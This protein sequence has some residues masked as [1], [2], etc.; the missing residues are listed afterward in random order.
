MKLR[1]AYLFVLVTASA[2][3][4]QSGTQRYGVFEHS[5]TAS[6]TYGN[7]YRE[8]DA[9]ATVVRPDGGFWRVPLF[10]DGENTWKLR[11]SPDAL[12]QWRYRIASNDGGLDG[13]SGTFTCT[14]SNKPGGIRASARRPGHFERQ[15]GALFWFMGDTAW[16]YFTDIADEK[17]DRAQAEL[18]AKARASQ[19]FNVIH[20]M[21][22]SEGGDGN[23]NGPPWR[24]IQEEQ[25][26]PGYFQEV[27]ARIRFAN[28]QGLT[29]G[30]AVAW[31]DKQRKEPFAWRRFPS[32]AARKRFARYAAARFG[33][34][35]TFF[36]VSGEWHGEVRTRDNVTDE[37]VF[38]EFVAI[39][40]ELAASN[41]HQ[42]MIGIH[43][44]TNHGSVREFAETAWMSF[45]D[46]QQNYAN[47]H[48]R[49]VISRAMPGPVVNSEYGY[50]LRDQNGDGVP[51]KSNSYSADDMRFSSWDIV[52]GGGYLV[53]GFGT[54]YFGGRRDPG[55]FTV[56][57]DKNRI[58]E[59]QMGFIRKFFEGLDWSKLTPADELISSPTPRGADRAADGTPGQRGRELRPP[60]T[61][62]WAMAD[63][64]QTY[65]VY[66]RGTTEPVA[67]QLGA[68]P[69]KFRLRQYNPRTGEFG[70]PTEMVI[71]D[72]HA[73]KAPDNSDWVF[74][75][76]GVE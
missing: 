64:G 46:Y 48:A 16:A 2:A 12:G 38:R 27:D 67:L 56:N 33:A 53:T 11:V 4:A 39:G 15:N 71:K 5:F 28:Q 41:P 57:A 51:D 26:N 1:S 32:V 60:T 62:Y 22:L 47:L 61:T 43:P 6:G 37:Q 13:Q 65:V 21:L 14:E 72:Q 54:T 69:R 70:Q 58:W 52:T 75:L 25:I 40:D 30:I 76:E 55:P 66:V 68:R 73:L 34:Y 63:P 7:A 35:D 29:V 19:G 49:T 10:W 45:A 50:F 20:S 24:S 74:L 23:Q 9:E 8:V 3:F 31:G 36:L 18:H 44:M 42:R 17:H 59:N